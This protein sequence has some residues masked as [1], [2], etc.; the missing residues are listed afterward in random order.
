[1]I[2]GKT[3]LAHAPLSFQ[4][5]PIRPSSAAIFIA[6]DESHLKEIIWKFQFF[7]FTAAW[8][9]TFVTSRQSKIQVV[10]NQGW[11]KSS[12]CFPPMRRRSFRLLPFDVFPDELKATGA[13]SFWRQHGSATSSDLPEETRLW[14]K[15]CP[16]VPSKSIH[17][18]K[19]IDRNLR[20][21]VV[22]LRLFHVVKQFTKSQPSRV[23]NL[24]HSFHWL[25]QQKLSFL[26]RVFGLLSQWK[27]EVVLL[28]DPLSGFCRRADVNLAV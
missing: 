19:N 14:A 12:Y 15:L 8:R 18:K 4:A 17:R 1:M 7:S 13:L 3:E 21:V 24:R 11:H 20:C 2:L 27:V 10:T 5:I 25:G 28:V 9:Y 6:F 26:S 23:T 16:F 22:T